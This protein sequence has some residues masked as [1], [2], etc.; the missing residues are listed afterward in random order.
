ML[1]IEPNDDEL[2]GLIGSTLSS[3][4]WIRD[5]ATSSGPHRMNSAS[6]A[7]SCSAR[8]S[9]IDPPDPASPAGTPNA[10]SS[11]ARAAA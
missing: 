6:G 9:G 8:R 10:S 11:A 2:A 1:R 4:A 7:A 5:R 3:D